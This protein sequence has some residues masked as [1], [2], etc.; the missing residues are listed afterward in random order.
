M[1]TGR[2]QDGYEGLLALAN[3]PSNRCGANRTAGLS[4][5]ERTLLLWIL[6]RF[7]EEGRPSMEL[8]RAAAADVGVELDTALET[9][10]REDLVHLRD[11]EIAVAYP[12]SGRP[13]T[14]RVRFQNGHEAFAMCAIDALGI[15]P[16]VNKPIQIRATDP[17]TGE[18][19]EVVLSSNGQTHWQPIESVVVVGASGSGN[20]F[21]GCCPVLNF[22]ASEENA[23]RWLSEHP[24]VQGEIVSLPEA[25]ELGRIVFGEVFDD[26]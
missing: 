14:H 4:A 23:Q 21:A 7:A 16:M 22:F 6:R 13:T 25:I 20:S 26:R 10:A 1:H 5:A 12:F 8:V 17:S 11:G 3:I 9:L 15:A 24:V 2:G 19:V 18:R